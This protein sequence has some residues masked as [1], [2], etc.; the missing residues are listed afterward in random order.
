MRKLLLMSGIKYLVN[1]S[2]RKTA[3]VINLSLHRRLWEDFH[4][5]LLAQKRKSEPRE[6][7]ADVRRK[8][9]SAGKLCG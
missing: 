6:A 5:T 1:K 7:L 3:V 4:D 2:G 8:L 9:V